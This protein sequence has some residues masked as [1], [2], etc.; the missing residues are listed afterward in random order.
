LNPENAQARHGRHAV[1]DPPGARSV[2]HSGATDGAPLPRLA[3]RVSASQPRCRSSR[4]HHA[5][6]PVTW[7]AVTV[8]STAC[9]ATQPATLWPRV[10]RAADAIARETAGLGRDRRADVGTAERLAQVREPT[11]AFRLACERIASA[12][13]SASAASHRPATSHGLRNDRRRPVGPACR[14]DPARESRSQAGRSG[15]PRLPSGSRRGS[16]C[17][18]PRADVTRM[19]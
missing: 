19:R 13:A 18:R 12:H 16:A 10:R 14:D 9:R 2:V 7:P 17:A 11:S 8:V 5:D 4:P 15:T 6:Q 1:P 3:M